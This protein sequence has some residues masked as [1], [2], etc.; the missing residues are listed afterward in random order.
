MKINILINEAHRTAIDKG[1][2]SKERKRTEVLLDVISELTLAGKSIDIMANIDAYMETFAGDFQQA[3]EKN[4]LGT[5]D[6]CLAEAF[7]KICD[8]TGAFSGKYYNIQKNFENELDAIKGHKIGSINEYLFFVIR[9]IQDIYYTGMSS[10]A[11]GESLAKILHLSN[12][13]GVDLQEIIRLRLKYCA[14]TS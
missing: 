9:N 4:I 3:Y 11:I 12:E 5:F 7:I 8:Y 13:L 14:K 10:W 6:E 1:W 2:W